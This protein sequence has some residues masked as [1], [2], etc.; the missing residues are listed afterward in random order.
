MLPRL[1]ARGRRLSNKLGTDPPVV[2][3]FASHRT[4]NCKVYVCG[5]LAIVYVLRIRKSA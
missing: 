5:A 3:Q 4:H 1:E 2:S